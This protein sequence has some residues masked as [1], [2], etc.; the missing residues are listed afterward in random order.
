MRG[1]GRHFQCLTGSKE[2]SAILIH[3]LGSRVSKYGALPYQ[4]IV[5]INLTTK[6]G[7]PVYYIERGSQ[8]CWFSSDVPLFHGQKV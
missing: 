3:I 1:A 2:K 6:T 5:V 7:I 8:T 4:C